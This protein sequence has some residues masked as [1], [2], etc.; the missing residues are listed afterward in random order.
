ME[1]G[2]LMRR[3]KIDIQGEDLGQ[4]AKGI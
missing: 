2:D 3:A 4:D 1:R